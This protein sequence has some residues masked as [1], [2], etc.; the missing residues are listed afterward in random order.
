VK[1]SS[2][3]VVEG[4]RQEEE[5]RKNAARNLLQLEERK[6]IYFLNEEES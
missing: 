2:T 5:R 4:E 3:Q 6:N 1:R